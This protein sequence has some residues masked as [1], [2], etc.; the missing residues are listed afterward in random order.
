MN[1]KIAINFQNCYKIPGIAIK[2]KNYNKKPLQKNSKIRKT[3]SIKA[4]HPID[5]NPKTKIQ[6]KCHKI[7]ALPNRKPLV[8]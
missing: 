4:T 3:Q 7:Q 1:F 6:E 2:L 5:F 8:H